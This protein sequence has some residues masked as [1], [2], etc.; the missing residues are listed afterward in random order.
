MIMI[1]NVPSP[2]SN[3]KPYLAKKLYPLARSELRSEQAELGASGACKGV[4]FLSKPYL[5]LALI[6][7]I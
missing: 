2:N 7:T 1:L 6:L 5:A 3:R 4:R